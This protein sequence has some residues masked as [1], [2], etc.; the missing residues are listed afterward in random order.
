[1]TEPRPPDHALDEQERE[2]ARILRV[3]PAG[4]PSPALDASILR[5]AANAAAGSRR[6]RSRWLAPLGSFWGV[7]GAAAAVLA[8]GVS[9]QMLDPS[10]RQ[11]GEST[12]PAS[13]SQEGAAD[14]AVL[15]EIGKSSR[16]LPPASQAPAPSP[17]ASAVERRVPRPSPSRSGPPVASAPPPEAFPDV[18][19]AAQV[20]A[21]A[22][23]PAPAS[24]PAPA[25]ARGVASDAAAPAQDFAESRESAA[26]EMAERDRTAASA[27]VADA[28]QANASQKSA[29]LALEAAPQTP[30]AWLARVRRLHAAD[31]IE[32]ARTSLREFRKQYPEHVIPSDLAPLLRE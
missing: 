12:S 22:S 8:L 11:A 17:P 27:A 30:A 6:P 4:E 7:G 20:E 26:S 1:M 13:A 9:W 21:P 32:E 18:P 15:V 24:A 19:M 3:L 5:A 14:S 29:A 31:R 25:L 23:P 2:I 10:H 16:E 28:A